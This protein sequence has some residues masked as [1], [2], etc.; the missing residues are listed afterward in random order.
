MAKLK[1]WLSLSLTRMERSF[2]NLNL[3]KVNAGGKE[4]KEEQNNRKGDVSTTVLNRFRFTHKL[5]I[6]S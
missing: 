3:V 2:L 5:L 4:E 6:T 1:D